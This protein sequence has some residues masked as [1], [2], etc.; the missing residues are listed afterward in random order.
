MAARRD[1]RPAKATLNSDRVLYSALRRGL[2]AITKHISD[3]VERLARLETSIAH[4][5]RRPEGR[6]LLVLPPLNSY[7]I[8]VST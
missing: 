2:S 1:L 5:N 4:R 6:R 3:R 8:E 7:L